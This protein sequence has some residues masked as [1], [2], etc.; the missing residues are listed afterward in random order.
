MEIGEVGPTAYKS[1]D[2]AA[3]QF[4]PV[5]KKSSTRDDL[6]R[7]STPA[8]TRLVVDGLFYI[9][10]AINAKPAAGPVV[11]V[12]LAPFE[13]IVIAVAP[14]HRPVVIAYIPQDRIKFRAICGDCGG[15][16]GFAKRN[17]IECIVANHELFRPLWGT[18]Q[19]TALIARAAQCTGNKID[20]LRYRA[21]SAGFIDEPA[22]SFFRRG[23]AL[24][25]C[26]QGRAA[27]KTQEVPAA[28]RH[29]ERHQAPLFSQS[30]TTTNRSTPD[31]APQTSPGRP[32]NC[33]T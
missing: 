28:D 33:R 20:S 17:A 26:G 12:V 6:H 18:Y 19:G 2:V 4:V 14:S 13:E 16:H 22:N 25:S 1:D 5:C 32:S 24:C 8:E 10:L 30:F 31:S 29:I 7:K 11:D 3:F 15:E 23:G 21:F 9:N 27:D